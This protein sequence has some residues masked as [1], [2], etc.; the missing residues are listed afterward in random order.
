M[1]YSVDGQYYFNK[2]E[3]I[4]QALRIGKP[5][6]YHFDD[7]FWEAQNWKVMPEATL[8]QLRKQRV[9]Q[10]RD[11]YPYIILC[12][13]GGADSWN[14]LRSF[15]E[16]DV[17]L[18]EIVTWHDMS[19]TGDRDS[20]TNG[21][22]FRAA[23]PAAEDFVLRHPLTTF[24]LIDQLDSLTKA[25][26]LPVEDL[27]NSYYVSPLSHGVAARA[28]HWVLTEPRYRRMIDAG[29][30]ICLLWG[31]DKCL[32]HLSVGGPAG[33]VP[34]YG[35]KFNDMPQQA[36][37]KSVFTQGAPIFDELFYWSADLPELP[38]K[39]LHVIK[40]N[41]EALPADYKDPWPFNPASRRPTHIVSKRGAKVSLNT[42]NTWVYDWNPNT[43][44]I[45]KSQGN[46]FL[47]VMDFWVKD[48]YAEPIV[49]KWLRVAGE[50]M[51]LYSRIGEQQ[52]NLA[53]PML[54]PSPIMF[55]KTHFIE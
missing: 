14:V 12:Y 54:G 39:Q 10:L 7:R 41:L 55:T 15:D 3:A 26:D 34:R 23:K 22:A 29:K 2:F 16:N 50:A 53:N 45:G 30:S 40:Q 48:H 25:L 46:H 20:P 6:N 8:R 28:G 1:N 18:D 4:A 33:P 13:S 31:Y 19:I 9:E 11:K 42:V 32:T 51:S 44:S 17:H 47:T 21:E 52:R 38:I 35:F 27:L 24:T 36:L 49:Q 5:V 37:R 43:F